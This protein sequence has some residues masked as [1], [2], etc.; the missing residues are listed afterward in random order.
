MKK[1]L[2]FGASTSRQSINKQ[3]AKWAA[4]QI[5]QTTSTLIDLNDFEMPIFSIDRERENG[6]PEEAK[7][8]KELVKNHD[9]ILISFAEHNGNVSAAFKN[10]FDWASRLEG[11]VWEGKPMFLPESERG[12]NGQRLLENQPTE[13]KNE[14][15]IMRFDIS[16][17]STILFLISTQINLWYVASLF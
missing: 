14:L 3:L 4:L 9:A 12:A 1:I 16:E 15:Y 17:Q 6:I 2:A 13:G 7:H 8:F 5:P 11:K 10:I